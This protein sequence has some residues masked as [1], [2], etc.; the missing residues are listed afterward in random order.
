RE[1]VPILDNPMLVVIA[2][3]I[4]IMG[5]QELAMVRH[6]EA[7]RRAREAEAPIVSAEP[8][9]SD[10]TAET[11]RP[12]F[13]GFLWDGRLGAWVL[14]RWGGRGARSSWA[15][16]RGNTRPPPGAAPRAPPVPRRSL[17]ARLQPEPINDSGTEHPAEPEASAKD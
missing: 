8:I 3:F 13:S 14:W 9:G 11:S 10:V 5:Q 4:A 17:Q 1:S 6:Q 15:A 7:V 2:G 12:G 16:P